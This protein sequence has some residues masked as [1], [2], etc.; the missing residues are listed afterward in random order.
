MGTE[1]IWLFG[2]FLI[3]S[4]ADG[5]NVRPPP[6]LTIVT[7]WGFGPWITGSRR[8]NS[9]VWGTYASG[10]H[11]SRRKRSNY[12]ILLC[13]L[14]NSLTKFLTPLSLLCS[15][16]MAGELIYKLKKTNSFSLSWSLSR[17]WMWF[18]WDE[19]PSYGNYLSICVID[20]VFWILWF[21]RNHIYK[22]IR[23]FFFFLIYLFPIIYVALTWSFDVSWLDSNPKGLW[24]FNTGMVF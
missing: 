21:W 12:L 16:V 14:T 5:D 15:M 4:G 3:R 24:L 7:K 20:L 8:A 2:D 22:Y 18:S 17:S 1:T 23:G 10:K 19:R 6:P 11:H 13:R 9:Q